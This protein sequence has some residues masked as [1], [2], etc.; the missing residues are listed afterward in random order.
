MEKRKD[1]FLSPQTVAKRAP[2]QGEEKTL[3]WGHI[4]SHQ[5]LYLPKKRTTNHAK[6]KWDRSFLFHLLAFRLGTLPTLTRGDTFLGLET[7][8]N[9]NQE[10]MTSASPSHWDSN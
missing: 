4:R 10:E 2:S 5:V 1:Q 8:L 9:T 3:S 7:A 6:E